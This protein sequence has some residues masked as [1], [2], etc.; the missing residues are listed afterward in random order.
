V[1]LQEQF[2]LGA[3]VRQRFCASDEIGQVVAMNQA[4]CSS[5]GRCGPARGV[6]WRHP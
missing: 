2:P 4:A 1:T 6:I 3:R 5:I